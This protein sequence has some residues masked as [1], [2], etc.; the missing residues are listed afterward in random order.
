MPKE[1]NLSA[2]DYRNNRR[3]SAT[4][5]NDDDDD[6]S[7]TESLLRRSTGT[8]NTYGNDTVMTGDHVE[9][10]LRL[11]R[12]TERRLRQQ[13]QQQQVMAVAG[14]APASNNKNDPHH[15]EEDDESSSDSEGVV[16]KVNRRSHSR[17]NSIGST[18]LIQLAV[19]A[20][21]EDKNGGLDDTTN[22]TSSSNSMQNN[23]NS[24]DHLQY[25]TAM[26]GNEAHHPISNLLRDRQVGNTT[27][28]N[29]AINNLVADNGN[30]SDKGSDCDNKSSSN[31]SNVYHIPDN[32]SALSSLASLAT[33]AGGSFKS[34]SD[35]ST[36]GGTGDHKS[37]I[38]AVLNYGVGNHKNHHDNDDSDHGSN[39]HDGKE[40]ANEERF[41]KSYSN[42]HLTKLKQQYQQVAAVEEEEFEN[43]EESQQHHNMH[44]RLIDVPH[45]HNIR[46][47]FTSLVGQIKD[48][49][50]E[51][52]DGASTPTP[53]PVSY[54][55][56]VEQQH[57]NDDEKAGREEV[58]EEQ[59][60][61]LRLHTES[62][63]PAA[64][65]STSPNNNKRRP[66]RRPIYRKASIDSIWSRRLSTE[67]ESMW[68]VLSSSFT[69]RNSNGNEGVA[70]G[71]RHSNGSDSTELTKIGQQQ[72][73]PHQQ[74]RLNDVSDD[75]EEDEEER[76]PYDD[77]DIRSVKS[78]ETMDSWIGMGNLGKVIGSN[79]V[80][81]DNG[82]MRKRG[83]GDGK[84]D[85][86]YGNGNGNNYGGGG[87]GGKRRFNPFG[88]FVPAGRRGSMTPFVTEDGGDFFY[89]DIV[90]TNS[91]FYRPGMKTL[92]RCGAIFILIAITALSSVL[93]GIYIPPTIDED[94][95][96]LKVLGDEGAE[97]FKLAESINQ[98]CE[99]TK[100]H[101][102]N[103]RRKC[104]KL[105]KNHLCCF[106]TIEDGYSCSGD[107]SK[108][109]GVYGGCEVLV[110]SFEGEMQPS[111]TK[112]QVQKGEALDDVV[113][114][115]G[116]FGDEF[117]DYNDDFVMYYD[118]DEK[119]DSDPYGGDAIFWNPGG[120]STTTQAEAQVGSFSVENVCTES[121]IKTLDGRNHCETL[122]KDHHCCFDLVPKKS[123]RTDPDKMC[124]TY[125][126][127][128]ILTLDIG[129]DALDSN[130]DG[131]T[132]HEEIKIGSQAI[133]AACAESN[134]NTP[135]GKQEC[136][137]VCSSHHCCFTHTDFN[138]RSDPD[139]NCP[140]YAAC[141]ILNVIAAEE[142]K[143]NG[144][145]Y[146][147][148]HQMGDNNSDP[149]NTVAAIQLNEEQKLQIKQVINKSCKRLVLLL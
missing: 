20:A 95:E 119:G 73:Y 129:T 27:N 8:A 28:S 39:S 130:S 97:L 103:G 80:N 77:S 42:P 65:S 49:V 19:T 22:T 21:A 107:E 63:G 132:T 70:Q 124:S 91:L 143:A 41:I 81:G 133:G 29:G 12:K 149:H 78:Q 140:A 127:C 142:G 67:S 48:R 137:A 17:S 94:I 56:R 128:E 120:Q 60:Y 62:D 53:P 145:V 23:I 83:G 112:D 46:S 69:R 84:G 146:Y 136:D 116:G 76:D 59:H 141:E 134:V 100:L 79:I 34:K 102:A 121:L 89:D 14:G 30:G 147:D 58:D 16:P 138:C 25:G 37:F 40:E 33:S 35:K 115:D 87:G 74:V 104:E 18:E 110:D 88:R 1:L 82:R 61:D 101:S 66:P 111:E 43:D 105:C 75:Q 26:G 106:D 57:H 55:D 135:S 126:S 38:S 51:N 13:Q 3:P 98:H 36:V 148:N 44:Q 9:A 139:K 71:R 72:Q 47:S 144:V 86:H 109:C 118:D 68:T 96:T 54:S 15:S 4:S 122:C 123:C 90:T 85:Y 45:Y 99:A 108:N 117:E 114:L 24:S 113:S 52:K 92:R 131:T 93:I 31:G 11:Q 2:Y 5:S 64:S 50:V 10:I 7:S 125:A 6:E 32:A